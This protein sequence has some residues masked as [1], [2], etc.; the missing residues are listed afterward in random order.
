MLSLFTMHNQRGTGITGFTPASAAT[1]MVSASVEA[2]RVW[3]YKFLTLL[4]AACAMLAD[5]AVAQ[6]QR[7]PA[8]KIGVLWSGT[9]EGTAPYWGAFIQG[10][11]ELGWIDGKT[12]HFIVRV[13]EGEKSRLPKL[14]AELVTLGVDVLAV[15]TIATA[16]ARS[17]TTTIP[18]VCTDASDPI[19]EGH[20]TTLRR[21]IGN[22]T[23]VSWQS[24]ETAIK[25]VELARELIPGLKRLGFLYDPSDST[26]IPELEGLRAAVAGTDVQLRTF[27]VRY[28]RDFP[29]A[30][31]A[32]KRY[33]PEALIYPTLV[34]MADNLE[35]TV[36]FAS[37]I[38]LPTFS[39]G[40]QFAEAGIFLTYG[41]DYLAAYKHAAT[42][43]DKILKGAKPATL[44]WEQAQEFEVVVN[45]KTAKAL[46]LTVPESIMVRATRIIR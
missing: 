42:Q 5:S 39:E 27:E 25:R 35:R 11:G 32:I 37:G 4:F 34:L 36:R 41:V 29:N 2:A 16:A 13:D 9:A 15:A 40:A 1:T 45:M 31:A 19:L 30:F 20:T 17:A 33:R 3:H 7:N 21:P 10:M 8:K 24:R 38:R 26:V 28:S 18:I 12:A 22:V 43:V 46:G 6:D 23:G 44:P 14:A